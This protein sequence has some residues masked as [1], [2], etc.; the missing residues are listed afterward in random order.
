M[1]VVQFRFTYRDGANVS[2][3]PLTSFYLADTEAELSSSVEGD[4]AYAKDTDSLYFY[5]STW[6]KLLVGSGDI[7]LTDNYIIRRNTADGS[8]NGYVA[9]AG[10]G[11][12]STTRGAV[13]RVTGNEETG[14]GPGHILGQLGNVTGSKLL[15]HRNDGNIILEATGGD[16]FTAIRFADTIV[17]SSDETTL[18]DYRE[19]EWTPGISF[20]NGTTGITYSIQ[21]GRVIKVG[22]KVT[23]WGRVV[24]TSKGSSSGLARITGL[25]H[26]ISALGSI[27]YVGK[28]VATSMASAS[29]YGFH[30]YGDVDSAT[31]VLVGIDALTDSAVATDTNFTNASDI[32]LEFSYKSQ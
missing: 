9:L 17:P 25:P 23:V 3:A 1:A 29:Y 19:K 15:I 4:L 11:A 22:R 16:G 30:V 27:R 7:V 2:S 18:D 31:D 28:V 6:K 12:F 20:G 14:V 21:V 8:D 5:T 26:P 13:F 24:L 10:G 32:S